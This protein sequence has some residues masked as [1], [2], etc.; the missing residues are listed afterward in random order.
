MVTDHLNRNYFF[1]A[2]IRRC[3]RHRAALFEQPRVAL[4]EQ[5]IARA[6]ATSATA[7]KDRLNVDTRALFALQN[8]DAGSPFRPAVDHTALIAD[9]LE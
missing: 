5:R 3:C 2:L 1:F 7:C 8:D 6:E 4:F 9:A